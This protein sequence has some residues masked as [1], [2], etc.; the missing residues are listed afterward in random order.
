MS[1]A[2]KFPQELWAG[3]LDGD[4]NKEECVNHVGKR[5]GTTLRNV[6]AEFYTCAIRSNTT[7]AE[8]KRAIYASLNHSF[9]TD[10]NPTHSLCPKG[11]KS[12]CYYN[13]SLA[14]YKIP[15]SHNTHI[16]TQRNKKT[17]LA[18]PQTPLAVTNRQKAAQKMPLER[19]PELK[20][21]LPPHSVGTSA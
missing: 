3:C 5:L 4:M 13:K 7:A 15:L 11:P 21:V 12:W 20:R 17:T 8:M 1:P 18:P 10:A 9:S 6:V 19:D 2:S 14:L 16:Q